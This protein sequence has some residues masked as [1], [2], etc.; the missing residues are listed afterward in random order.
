MSMTQIVLDSAMRRKLNNL[1][2]PADLVDEAGK[3]L[4]HLIPVLDPADWKPVDP[5]LPEEEL[6][7][8]RKEP[9]YSTAEVL[10][11]LEGL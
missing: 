11:Y 4:A 2:E 7:R 5:D 1:R 3:I 8:R 10:E 6:E 9:D